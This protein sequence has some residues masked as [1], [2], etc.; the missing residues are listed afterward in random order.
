MRARIRQLLR[1]RL[2][3]QVVIMMV[4][5][6]VV[7]MAAGFAVVQWN[8]NR[9]LDDQYEQ[10]SLAVAQSLASQPGLQQAVRTGSPG[11]IGPHG[12]VQSMAMAAMRSTAAT[13]VVVTNAKGIRLSHP[14]PRLIGTPVWYPDKDL[15][16]SETFRTGQDWMGIEHGTLGVEA[17]GK[18]PIFGHGKLVGEVSVGFLTATVAGHVARTLVDLAVYFL[19]VLALGVL[20]ALGLSRLLK[21][22]TFGLELRE[23]AALLQERE[24]MLHGIREGVLGYDKNERIV[25]AND[26]ARQLLDLLPEF[27]GRPLRH[28]LP[29]GRLADVVTGEIEGSDLLVLHGDR[30]LVANRMPIQQGHRHLGWVVTFQDRTESEALKRQLDD[31]IGLTETLRAQSHEFANRLHTLV[32][33]VE[34]GRNDEAIQFVTD[35]SAARADLTERLQADIGDAKLVAMILGKVSLADERDVRLRV[36]DDSH[37]SAPISDVSQVLTVAG[38]LI[39]NAI[40]AAAQAPGPRWVEL[41]I[42]AVEHDLLVRVR[43]SGRGVPHNMR[44]AIFMDGVT[45]K[46]ST[47]GARRG[48]GLAL[49]RKVVEGRGGMISVGHDS[50]AVFTAVLPQLRRRGPENRVWYP[51]GR[52]A[53]GAE[54]GT[55][56]AMIRV[57]VVDDDFRIAD[58]HAAYV[59]KVDGFQAIAQ[60]HTAAE[61]VGAVDRLRP[62]LLLL[63]L[64]L[65]DEHGLDLV[66]RLRREGHPPVDV[67]VITAAKDADSVRAA[68]QGGALHYLLKPFSFPA[69]RDKLL[70]YAQMRSRLNAL[71]EP[72]QRNLDRVFGALRTQDQLSGAKGRS[73]HTL[74]AVERLLTSGGQ[75]LSAAEVAEMTGMSRATAQRY[76]SHLHEI[77]RVEIR[78]RYGSGGR[79]EHRYRWCQAG[80]N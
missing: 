30:V 56:P 78:L 9:Q 35:V 39:D 7:T 28:V 38:N 40:D 44:E 59:D 67:I 58:I 4:A 65:P 24:A 42:V 64:Y 26:F 21:R 22:Q 46:T 63:D 72:D 12:A 31:A 6:L 75:E 5:I 32:G 14:N 80:E 15:P 29:P 51:G 62:D 11:G 50:G 57:V 45:T 61:A 53:A 41:T 76:L 69:L 20:A 34:L 60:A 19:A 16:S 37:V 47:T 23:I 79:P 33:L 68:M 25:L 13:F 27:V 10:R 70:S 3:T 8:L 48:L 36:M 52:C 73:A 77:G 1:Q 71:H 18:A 54:G 17:V 55:C 74:E 2:S 49:V 43:D 66:A